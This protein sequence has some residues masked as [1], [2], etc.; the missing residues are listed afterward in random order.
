[1]ARV[2]SPAALADS[3]LPFPAAFLAE[4]VTPPPADGGA[5]SPSEFDRSWLFL[6]AYLPPEQWASPHVC[7]EGPQQTRQALAAL[8]RLHAHFWGRPAAHMCALGGGAPGPSP[9][10]PG[11]WWRKAKRPTVMVERLPVVFA[12]LCREFPAEFASLDKPNAHDAFAR[13]VA[14][15][16]ALSAAVAGESG[17][18]GGGTIVHGDCKASNFF[19]R[20]PPR[21]EGGEGGDNPR[22]EGGV[23]SLGHSGG[24]LTPRPA[25]TVYRAEGDSDDVI[26]TVDGVRLF[27]FQWAGPA[28]SGAA[29]VAYLLTGA[30]AAD[31]LEATWP[32]LLQY[33]YAQLAAALHLR[34]GAGATS[35]SSMERYTMESF[36]RDFDLEMLDLVSAILPALLDGISPLIA[37]ENAAKFGWL[38]IESDPRIAAWACSRALEAMGRLP[39]GFGAPDRADGPGSMQ[40]V[41]SRLN[42]TT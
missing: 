15:V 30:V 11:A 36:L 40:K 19:F 8:A 14:L 22:G 41:S 6:T 17:S 38:T 2:C 24:P 1:M 21:G 5:A 42:L 35:S 16:P 27:D 39:E 37:S 33:Y 34:L 28:A 20:A 26:P 23:G 9:L 31:E 29:D 18:S 3:G 7:L 13:L 25:D 10:L 4:E 12:Q 32:R